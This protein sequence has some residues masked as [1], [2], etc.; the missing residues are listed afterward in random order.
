MLMAE[1]LREKASSNS[2]PLARD[3]T[4]KGS[5]RLIFALIF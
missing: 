1:G 3:W 5:G 4:N 2:K